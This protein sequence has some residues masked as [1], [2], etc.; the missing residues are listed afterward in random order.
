MILRI[1]VVAIMLSLCFA[2]PALPA[3]LDT[4]LN[5]PL[6][7]FLID[8]SDFMCPVC[9][10]SLLSVCEALPIHLHQENVRGIVLFSKKNSELH[11]ENSTQILL[12]KIRGFQK[13]NQIRFP[14]VL[15]KDGIFASA[16]GRGSCLIL[17]DAAASALFRF[18]IPLS[19]KEFSQLLRLLTKNI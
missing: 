12:K 2:V 5:D 11:A 19:Q 9:L 10:D 14:L 4:G 1:C 3:L 17:F 8:F 18:S 7:L 16:A 6:V 15:D 13:A